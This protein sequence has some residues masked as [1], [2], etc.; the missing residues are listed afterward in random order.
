LDDPTNDKDAACHHDRPTPT[1]R[2]CKGCQ[3]GA[4]KAATSEQGN[5]GTG[6]GVCIFLQEQS[7]EG[8]RR[9][10]FCY[11]AQVVAEEE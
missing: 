7:L 5:N 8:V 10:D 2:I 4:D 3:E 6:A 1:K 9:N 11:D